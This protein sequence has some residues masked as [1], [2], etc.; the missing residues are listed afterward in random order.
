LTFA[1]IRIKIFLCE[2]INETN[3]NSRT[4]KEIAHDGGKAEEMPGNDAV[5]AK[6]KMKYFSIF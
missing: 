3:K 6:S 1:R 2:S 4:G 5:I